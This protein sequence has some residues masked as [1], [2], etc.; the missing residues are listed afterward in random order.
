[1][2]NDICYVWWQQLLYIFYRW[3]YFNGI[4][5]THIYIYSVDLT[6]E[7][8]QSK[9][10]PKSSF[11]STDGAAADNV[12]TQVLMIHHQMAEQTTT[13]TDWWLVE[14]DAEM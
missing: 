6:S 13:V 5:Q 12:I 11:D 4:K 10:A 3:L 7:P 9:I 14:E 8:L 2:G 1:M